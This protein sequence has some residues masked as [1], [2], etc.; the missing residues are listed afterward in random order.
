MKKVKKAVKQVKKV[1]VD[2]SKLF[3]VKG[4]QFTCVCL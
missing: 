2:K 4:T 1:Q 3:Q